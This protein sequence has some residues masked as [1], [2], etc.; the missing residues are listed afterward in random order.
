MAYKISILFLFTGMMSNT[1]ILEAKVALAP[2]Q[3][4]LWDSVIFLD[5]FASRHILPYNIDNADLFC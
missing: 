4:T 2:L 5:L 3:Q 1:V